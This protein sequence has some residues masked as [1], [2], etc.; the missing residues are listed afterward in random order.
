MQEKGFVG[1]NQ[2][3]LSRK[4]YPMVEQSEFFSKHVYGQLKFEMNSYYK[5]EQPIV[6]EGLIT[7]YDQDGHIIEQDGHIIEQELYKDGELIEKIK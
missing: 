2:H 5:K 6:Y 4:Y 3:N 7:R 1:Y